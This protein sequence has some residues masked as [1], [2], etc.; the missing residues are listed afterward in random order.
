MVFKPVLS[1]SGT[2]DHCPESTLHQLRREEQF[3][4][5]TPEGGREGGGRVREGGR[6]EGEGGREGGRMRERVREGRR[7]G[8]ERGR[9]RER[10]RERGGGE[11]GWRRC[12]R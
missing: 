4:D 3:H 11:R 6:E 2:L 1:S 12:A 7:E 5:S 10:L 8:G 9:G